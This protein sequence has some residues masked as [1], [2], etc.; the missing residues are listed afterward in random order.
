MTARVVV[1]DDDGHIAFPSG[2]PRPR[3]SCSAEI[4][5]TRTA[6]GGNGANA[7]RPKASGNRPAARKTI[8]AASAAK[9][10]VRERRRQARAISTPR[11][12]HARQ[13]VVE[14]P[15]DVDGAAGILDQHGVEALLPRVDG[16]PGDAE[17]G[18][19]AG[20]EKAHEAAFAQVAG[21]AGGRAA[22][23]FVKGGIGIDFASKPLRTMSSARR[24]SRSG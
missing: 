8:F 3:K 14:R 7:M 21:K 2:Q 4:F 13:R 11:R 23:V 16:R 20:Q 12:L 6:A 18:G 24:R 15:V 9:A 1:G 17:V 22:V 10:A 19:E 5:R